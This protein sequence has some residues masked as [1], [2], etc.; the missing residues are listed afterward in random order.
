MYAI[1]KHH[2]RKDFYMRTETTNEPT[3][4]TDTH[5]DVVKALDCVIAATYFVTAYGKLADT[6][7][8]SLFAAYSA[9][10]WY[11]LGALYYA[12]VDMPTFVLA[13]ITADGD[14]MT[15]VD[16]MYD[17]TKQLDQLDVATRD[18]YTADS[19]AFVGKLLQGD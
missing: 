5:L 17:V 18:K 14:P 10:Q 13:V 12:L 9:D 4:Y 7:K 2:K 8:E 1:I 19:V 11:S 6:D 15:M 3:I 16:I